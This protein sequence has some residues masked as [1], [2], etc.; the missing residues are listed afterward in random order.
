[1]FDFDTQEARDSLTAMVKWVTEDK[2]MF[3]GLIPTKNSFVTIRLGRGAAGYGCGADETQPLSAMAY[4][5]TWGIPAANNERPPGSTT[6]FVYAALPPMVGTEHR[7]VQNAGFAFAVPRTSNKQKVAWDIAKSIA[8]SPEAMR[9]WTAT[10]GTIP[11]LKVNGT[12]EATAADP[13]LSKVQSLL[14]QGHWMGDIPY[15]ST[16]AVLGAMVTNFFAAVNGA[17]TIER[18][19]ADMQK[20]ANDAIIQNR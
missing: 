5:G 20:T 7:F 17:K 11:A 3:P 2:I 9:K 19:L 18:A 14:E 12:K 16:Q 10:A 15:G 8:L 4:V 6:R 13:V 1:M